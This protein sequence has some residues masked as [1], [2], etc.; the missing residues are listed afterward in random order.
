MMSRMLL[1]PADTRIE[2]SIVT[3][4]DDDLTDL[5]HEPSSGNTEL[6]FKT[7]RAHGVQ[8]CYDD[9]GLFRI[10]LVRNIRAELLWAA[11]A[12]VDRADFTQPLAG[13][14]VMLGLD[15]YSGETRHVPT[16]AASLAFKLWEE[17]SS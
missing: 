5:V 8:F 14:F 4:R 10:P 12:G 16:M 7:F 11:L 6:D 9:L 13:N 2:M 15:P 3:H 1:I 17:Y